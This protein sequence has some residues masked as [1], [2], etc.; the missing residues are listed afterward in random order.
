MD[1]FQQSCAPQM[2]RR[3]S[4]L[5]ARRRRRNSL[6][7][8]FLQLRAAVQLCLSAVTRQWS[9]QRLFPPR[10]RHNCLR[11]R[12]FAVKS[13]H[14]LPQGVTDGWCQ[15]QQTVP[16]PPVAECQ[17]SAPCV[18]TAQ[19]SSS[20][21]FLTHCHELSCCCYLSFFFRVGGS[22]IELL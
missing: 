18:F 10:W 3:V 5:F 7:Q 22:Q 12:F 16:D 2:R 21:N 4:F 9:S 15:N 11:W 17:W 13:Y 14:R 8:V 20:L 19:T 6:F 1:E